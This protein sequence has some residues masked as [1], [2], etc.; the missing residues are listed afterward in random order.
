MIATEKNDY[1]LFCGIFSHTQSKISYGES[2][3]WKLQ[4]LFSLVLFAQIKNRIL[5]FLCIA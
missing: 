5:E 2:V 3:E 1:L 4:E